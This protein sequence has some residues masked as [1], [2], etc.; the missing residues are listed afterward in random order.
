MSGWGEQF[1]GTRVKK[2]S[3]KV[4]DSGWGTQFGGKRIVQNPDDE[5]PSRSFGKSAL[6]QVGRLARAGATGIAGLADIPNLASLGLHA[7][8]LK[9]DP[10]FY[11]PI[12][13][14][15]QNVI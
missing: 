5:Q 9:E 14:K 6:R 4:E 15:V 13:G 2:S 10:N 1:G 3:P 8:G 7:A 11:E 12:A